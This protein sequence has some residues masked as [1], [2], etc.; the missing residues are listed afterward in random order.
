MLCSP[1]GSPDN[2]DGLQVDCKSNKKGDETVVDVLLN[3]IDCDIVVIC[4][5]PQ[6]KKKKERKK[7]GTVGSGLQF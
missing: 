5:P 4:L 3:S 6:K 2:T 7:K 1:W